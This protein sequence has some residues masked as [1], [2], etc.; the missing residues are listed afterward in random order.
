VDNGNFELHNDQILDINVI[1]HMVLPN[2]DIDQQEMVHKYQSKLINTKGKQRI[3][4][5]PLDQH[6]L[7]LNYLY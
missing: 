4:Q 6:E 5:L 3:I 7:S 2:Y 1:V